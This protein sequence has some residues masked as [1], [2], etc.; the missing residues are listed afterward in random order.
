MSTLSVHTKTCVM[1]L[2]SFLVFSDVGS[3]VAQTIE[4]K[5]VKLADEK[6]SG[7][8]AIDYSAG[9]GIPQVVGTGFLLNQDGYFLTAAHVVENLND[10]EIGMDLKN[11]P[12]RVTY[13][14]SLWGNKPNLPINT[15]AV[16]TVI[17]KD[18][19]HDI[20]LCKVEGLRNVPNGRDLYPTFRVSSKEPPVGSFISVIGFPLGTMTP[21]TQ[22][23]TIAAL[24]NQNPA[25]QDQPSQNDQ[26]IQVAVL[27]NKGNSGSPVIDV[28]T[29]EVVGMIVQAIPAPLFT[30]LNLNIPGFQSSGLML[31]VPV[32]W[33]NEIL[34]KHQVVPDDTSLFGN[35][36]MKTPARKSKK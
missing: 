34:K 23:G 18:Q 15:A 29:G 35:A 27:G 28:D 22:F 24:H 14:I 9:P 30:N 19:F 12:H 5:F 6:M 17:E 33:I 31:A 8:V 2:A 13:Q 26:L 36:S 20:A 25:R 7:V 10:G 1:I 11:L 4:Q 32:M 21:T 16:L 3:I